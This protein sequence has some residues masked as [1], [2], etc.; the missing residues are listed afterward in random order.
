MN[1]ISKELNGIV[2]RHTGSHYAVKN[3]GVGK[4]INCVVRGRL[5]LNA[6][7]TTN[8]VTVGDCVTFEMINDAE[9]VITAVQPRRNY[10]IR[11]ATNLSSET[12]IIAANIDC[13]YLIATIA[14]PHNAWKFI[15]RFLVTCE[16]YKV[17]VKIVI[18]KT[19]LYHEV[20]N[21][22]KNRFIQIYTQ[23][24]YEVIEVSATTGLHIDTL[25]DDIKGR[26]CLFSGASGVGKSS[27]INAIDPALNLRIGKLSAAHLKGMHTTTFYEVF[28]LSSGGCIIDSPGIKGFGLVDV[29]KEELYHFFPELFRTAA[30]CKFNPCTHIHE[31]HCAVLQ[32]IDKGEIS[33]ERYDSYLKMF[34]D[35]NEKYR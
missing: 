34:Y 19:D 8:P 28:E 33:E 24:G 35:D 2:F 4:T 21:E 6:S 1:N 31:P 10:I 3:K 5:R 30:Q 7:G 11:R 18:N 9:G 27:L 29:G 23:A 25:R 15:D 16:A 12:H 26:F 22:E 17:P 14:H 32:A 20:E 13:A